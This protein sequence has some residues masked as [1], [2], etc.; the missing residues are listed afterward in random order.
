MAGVAGDG[1]GAEEVVKSRL[2]AD[3]LIR[4]HDLRPH[5]E[6]GYF[7]ETYRSEE[8]IPGA[9]LPPRYGGDRHYS[10]AIHYLLPSGATS[11]LHR[12]ASDEIWHFYL[13]GPLTI[14]ELR[15][16]RSTEHVILGPD[17]HNGQRVQHVVKAGTWFGAYPNRGTE[18][19]FVGCTVAPGFSFRDFQVA[20]RRDLVEQ[21]SRE[22]KV[23]AK[24]TE[25]D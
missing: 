7:R 13:G 14:V 17:L 24:L 3:E 9:C 11:R 16:D 19:C 20:R 22:A 15:P 18:Y 10:T 5:P 2:T 8:S 23:I 25:P 21:F 6:G 1:D 4:I 12:L